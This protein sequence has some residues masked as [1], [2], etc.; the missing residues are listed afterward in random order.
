MFDWTYVQRFRT[1]WAF[2]LIELL[3]VVVIIGLLAA[4]LLSAAAVPDSNIRC[5][6]IEN[7]EPTTKLLI[8][9]V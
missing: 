3:V 7:R 4:L 5:R 6:W 2:I 9:M 8:W 1:T